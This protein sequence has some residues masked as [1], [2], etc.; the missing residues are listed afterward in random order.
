MYIFRIDRDWPSRGVLNARGKMI[1]AHRRPPSAATKLEHAFGEAAIW[2]N[3][4]GRADRAAWRIISRRYGA[5]RTL[6]CPVTISSENGPKSGGNRMKNRYGQRLAWLEVV[7]AAVVV[8]S[9]ITMA[10]IVFMFV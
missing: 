4:S 8:V 1:D 5:L 7:S 2:E 6:W 10:A 3:P 9:L